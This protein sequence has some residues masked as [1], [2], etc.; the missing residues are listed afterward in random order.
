MTQMMLQTFEMN[1]W[2]T[3]TLIPTFLEQLL[4]NK[5]QYQIGSRILFQS[6]E[7]KI[8]DGRIF[9]IFD[10]ELTK[11]PVRDGGNKLKLIVMNK[12]DKKNWFKITLMMDFSNKFVEDLKIKRFEMKVLKCVISKIF[13]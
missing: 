4:I 2:N 13:F 3:T 11:N 7:L 6:V 1:F 9:N 5:N 10:G 8:P 12:M